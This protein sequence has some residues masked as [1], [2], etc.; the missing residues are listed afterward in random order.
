MKF[1]MS[2]AMRV[3]TAWVVWGFISLGALVAGLFAVLD[4]VGVRSDAAAW[5]QAIGSIGAILAAVILAQRAVDQSRQTNLMQGYDYMRKAYGVAAYASETIIGAGEY[6]GQGAPTE[7]MLKYHV[8]LL[9]LSLEDMRA[10]DHTKLDDLQVAEAFLSLKR[11]INLTRSTIVSS[12]EGDHGFDGDQVRMWGKN[13]KSEVKEMSWKL[14]RYL[15]MHPRLLD[16]VHEI[17]RQRSQ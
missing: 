10:I 5:V 3:A 9:E 11:S 1:E 4:Y 15:S 14:I 12:L 2:E 13:A 8:S 17:E 6:I 7:Q 16:K